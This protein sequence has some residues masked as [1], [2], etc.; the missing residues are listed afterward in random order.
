MMVIP[1]MLDIGR[2]RL[3][4]YGGLNPEMAARHVVVLDS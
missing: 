3:L 1:A 4:R 2:V